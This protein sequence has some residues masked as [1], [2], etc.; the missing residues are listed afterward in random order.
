MTKRRSKNRQGFDG[1]TIP[2]LFR[3]KENSITEYANSKKIYRP[4]FD[5]RRSI[6][7]TQS[8]NETSRKEKRDQI[9]RGEQ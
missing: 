3:L 6:N 2:Q 4:L 5:R 1:I 8:G 7:T 9:G